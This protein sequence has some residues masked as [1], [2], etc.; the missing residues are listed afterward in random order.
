MKRYATLKI[1]HDSD[2]AVYNEPAMPKGNCNCGLIKPCVDGIRD[3]LKISG[4]FIHEGE[5]DGIVSAFQT[6]YNFKTIGDD[7]QFL[8]DE[9]K[10]TESDYFDELGNC[11][12]SQGIHLLSPEMELMRHLIYKLEEIINQKDYTDWAF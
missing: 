10:S 11:Y 5:K 1:D 9:F 2:C 8:L 6:G 4:P 7:V 12:P 3:Y